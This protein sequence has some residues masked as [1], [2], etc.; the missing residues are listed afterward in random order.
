MKHS[1]LREIKIEV[2]KHKDI[3]K[4]K[5]SYIVPD[6]GSPSTRKNKHGARQ[7]IPVPLKKLTETTLNQIIK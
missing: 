2:Q 7:Q 1:S 4:L 6:E 3:N 5:D